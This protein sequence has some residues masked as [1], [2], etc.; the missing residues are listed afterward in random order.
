LGEIFWADVDSSSDI[1]VFS[2]FLFVIKQDSQ[3]SK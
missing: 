3:W 1:N 2:N